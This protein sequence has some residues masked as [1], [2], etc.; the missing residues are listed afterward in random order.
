MAFINVCERSPLVLF[1]LI[2]ILAEST[3]T[4]KNKPLQ[5]YD[6][7]MSQF[8]MAHMKGEL[9]NSTFSLFK[10][11]N[12]L[13]IEKCAISHLTPNTFENTHLEILDINDNIEF[14]T[15]TSDTFK[16]L[17]KLKVFRFTSNS[18]TTIEEGSFTKLEN[19]DVLVISHQ[20][21][22]NI[23]KSFLEGLN[24]L[25]ELSLTFN[26]VEYIN[27][28]AFEH[29]K[30]LTAIFLGNNLIKTIIPGTFKNQLK[31]E[32]LQLQDNQLGN[33]ENFYNINWKNFDRIISLR[34]LNIAKN[35]L[36][37]INIKDLV[38]TFPLLISVN[39]L[40][41]N[42]TCSNELYITNKL[43]HYRI[44]IEYY[45]NDLSNC[46]KFDLSLGTVVFDTNG[47]K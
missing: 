30:E 3:I 41:N 22:K 12:G 39:F 7:R 31:L 21:L 15:I 35:Y 1:L 5:P 38:T 33:D 16:Y 43:R 34:F 42:M 24:N 46:K 23:T 2:P 10:N 36:N 19:L 14:P 25:R 8:N 17:Q 9:D 40:P 18:Y 27:Q 44:Q 45:G 32:D 20:F 37:Y 29:M 26:E 6:V 13:K 11:L 28:D 4:I 47:F